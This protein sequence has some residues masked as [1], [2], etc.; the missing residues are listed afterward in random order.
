MRRLGVLHLLLLV[1]LQ[2]GRRERLLSRLIVRRGRSMLLVTLRREALLME[3]LLASKC[4]SVRC[5]KAVGL[6]RT[7]II[8]GRRRITV[9]EVSLS[10]AALVSAS[11]R[12][13][14]FLHL[15]R[16]LRLRYMRI[17]VLLAI[18]LMTRLDTALIKQ[19][20]VAKLDSCSINRR[21]LRGIVLRV[22]L[23]LLL[24]TKAWRSRYGR[25][26]RLLGS[27]LLMLLLM[28][29]ILLLLLVHL[30]LQLSCNRRLAIVDGCRSDRGL[31][32][33]ILS[34]AFVHFERPSWVHTFV[35]QSRCDIR[36]ASSMMV[37]LLV[38]RDFV[39]IRRQ[40]RLCPTLSNA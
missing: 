36:R 18:L 25:S 14:T 32:R 16:L 8:Y 20:K 35:R 29:S 21:V 40:D 39:A 10:S 1:V 27:L 22:T 13:M 3:V 15:R 24:L 9:T 37:G 31:E 12:L 2:I 30:S 7:S 17:A 4:V 38:S 6:G 34:G 11:S 23:S 33:L 28:N 26:R 5:A 19:A